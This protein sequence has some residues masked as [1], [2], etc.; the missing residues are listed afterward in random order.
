MVAI[1]DNADLPE[2]LV[3]VVVFAKVRAENHEAAARIAEGAITDRMRDLSG[4]LPDRIKFTRLSYGGLAR[5]RWEVDVTLGPIE[6]LS[7]ALR[8][9][10]LT[11]M[12]VTHD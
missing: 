9:D 6:E 5:T 7:A 12:A 8:K 1:R 3:P 10:H 4:L 2:H 11:V